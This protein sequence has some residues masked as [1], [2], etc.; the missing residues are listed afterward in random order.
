SPTPATR[1]KL[2]AAF[3]ERF[4]V[5]LEYLGGRSSDLQTRLRGERAAGIYTVD[6]LIGGAD[7]S[8]S[9]H[10]EGWYAP[11]RPLLVVPAVRP[12][13]GPPRCSATPASPSSIRTSSRCSSSSRRSPAPGS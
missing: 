8:V 11:I 12:R 7:S 5:E 10:R 9:M 1:L 3:K 4:G 2:P 13:S 6:V